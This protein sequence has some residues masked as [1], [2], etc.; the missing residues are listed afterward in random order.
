M[1]RLL[2]AAVNDRTAEE[3]KKLSATLHLLAVQ[4]ELLQEENSGLRE[5]LND[6]KKRK[7]CGKRLDLQREDS[8]HGGATFWSPHKIRQ[9][10]ARELEKQ[11]QEEAEIAARATRKEL[12]AAAKALQEQEKEERRVERE[13]LK[14]E[15]ACERAGKLATRE[16]RIAAQNTTKAIQNAPPTKRKASQAAPSK[17]KRSRRSG[18][19]AAVAASPEA[20]PAAPLKLSSRSRAITLSQKLR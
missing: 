4:N 2:R 8:Y 14:D 5:A 19:G 16:A 9:A 15:R 11:Q 3:S 10:W 6:K 20:A 13:R 12:Q 18:N 17:S 1:E 7:D